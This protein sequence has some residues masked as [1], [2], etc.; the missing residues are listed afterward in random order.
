MKAHIVITGVALASVCFSQDFTNSAMYRTA[1]AVVAAEQKAGLLKAALDMP[2][3]VEGPAAKLDVNEFQLKQADC[4]GQVVELTFDEVLT[5]K[6]ES[7]A[8]YVATV[9]FK[10]EQ[11]D[12]S[13]SS[14]VEIAVP[15]EGLKTFQEVY[16]LNGTTRQT[17]V[18][19]QVLVGSKVRALGER[20][21]KDNPEG[22]RYVW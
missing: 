6:Q 15:P 14:A 2:Q 3:P 18:M 20:Y 11:R 21:R 10:R 5:L 7:S 22:E 17:K 16:L 4:V 9:A 19:V 12:G 13:R 1:P 8:G